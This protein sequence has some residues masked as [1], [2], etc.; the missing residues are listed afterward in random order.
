MS[1]SIVKILLVDD[2]VFMLELLGHMLADLGFDQVT[3]CSDGQAALAVIDAIDESPDL[4]LLDLN[5]PEMDG[6]QFVYQLAERRY[7][8]SLVPVSAEDVRMVQA[9]E[10][11]ALVHGITVLGHLGKPVLRPALSALL[12][13]WSPQE[14]QLG[15]E[16]KSACRFSPERLAEAIA[17]GELVNYYQPKVAVATGLVVGVEA[18]VRWRHPQDGMVFPDRFIG[19]AEE[20]GLID[21]LTQVVLAGA[22]AQAKDWRLAGLRLNIAVNVSVDNLASLDF[23]DRLADLVSASGGMPSE[24]LLEVTESRL[25]SE[26]HSPLETLTR[27]RLKRFGL[28]IDDFGTG[29]SS[30][31]QLRH[32]PFDQLKIDKSFV[33]LASVDDT[34]RAIYDASLGLAKQ[35]GLEAVAEGVEDLEDWALLRRTQ[36]DQAQ[37]YFIARPMPPDELPGWMDA[38]RERLPD[39]LEVRP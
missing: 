24:L 20:Y 27:L 4:I 34:L 18:L 30:L 32:I 36:C 3:A 38:W 39:L 28:A 7:T 11:L 33:H 19:V 12:A 10:R 8:G 21:Q 22:V 6:V 31:A 29:Y 1:K 37:G 35:L 26:R 5:M 2:D 14:P 17:G 25:M 9:V 13:G 15:P 23:P 16:S